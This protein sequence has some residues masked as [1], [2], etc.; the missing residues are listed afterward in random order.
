MLIVIALGGNALLK[1]GEALTLA[2]QKRNIETACQVIAQIAKEHQVVLT[3]GNGPQVGL[4]ALQAAAFNESEH[5]SFD[6]LGA[7]SEGMIGYLLEQQLMNELPQHKIAALLT[8]VEVSAQDPAFKQPTK[9]IGPVYTHAQA[10]Q[11]RAAHP[12]WRLSV[13]GAYFRRVIASPQPMQIIEINTIKLLVDSKVLVICC[14]GGGIP[15]IKQDHFYRGVEA[16]IDKDLAAALLAEQLQADCLLMLT[17]VS[18][19]MKNWGAPSAEPIQRLRAG[20]TNLQDFPAGSMRPKIEAA[21]R[22]AQSSG[23]PAYIGA[24]N[25]AVSILQNKSGTLI[26]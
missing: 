21:K 4:L 11:V 5:F 10:D 17:D 6:V 18:A 8:Q 20:Q 15:V 13:D 22:F 16:V 9:F 2:A 3:H 12:S 1:R 19:V 24:L 23:K 14:G 7:E 26:Y 25:D